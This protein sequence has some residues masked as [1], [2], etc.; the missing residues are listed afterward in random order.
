MEQ[1]LLEDRALSI[2]K[3]DTFLLEEL[4]CIDV[5]ET[6][7]TSLFQPT[8]LAS[9]ALALRI[10]TGFLMEPVILRARMF[11]RMGILRFAK[12]SAVFQVGMVAKHSIH[13]QKKDIGIR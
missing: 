6:A 9:L 7:G 2:A 1:L 12:R 8:L 13:A 4:T 3:V 10:W 5:L 11:Q